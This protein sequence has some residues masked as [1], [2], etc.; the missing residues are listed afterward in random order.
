MTFKHRKRKHDFRAKLTSGEIRD[1]EKIDLEIV[2]VDAKRR[3][4]TRKRTILVNRAIQRCR[5]A[6]GAR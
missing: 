4:L 1:L 5:H 2:V 6:A 3:E